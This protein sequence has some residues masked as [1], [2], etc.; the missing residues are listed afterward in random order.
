LKWKEL[1]VVGES[2]YLGTLLIV[3]LR[4][5]ALS[6]STDAYC[7]NAG[8]SD[9]CRILSRSRTRILSGRR[10]RFTGDDLGRRSR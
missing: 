1:V 8:V 9:R 5:S 2:N 4:G 10:T 3:D 6:T 7:L